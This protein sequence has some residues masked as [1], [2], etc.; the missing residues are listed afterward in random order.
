LH[1][2]LGRTL[3]DKDLKAFCTSGFFPAY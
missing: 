1:F 3:V 2:S